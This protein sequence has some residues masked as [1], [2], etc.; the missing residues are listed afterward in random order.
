MTFLLAAIPALGVT[1]QMGAS[2]QAVSIVDTF[3][4]QVAVQGAGQDIDPP[5]LEG[6][7]FQVLSTGTQ[8]SVQIFNGRQSSTLI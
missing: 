8:S 1:V 5:Q 2:K 6:E 3:D 4:L 7:G